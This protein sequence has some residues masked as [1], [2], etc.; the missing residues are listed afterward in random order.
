MNSG[1]NDTVQWLTDLDAHLARMSREHRMEVLMDS[2]AS[3][4][5]VMGRA[6]VLAVRSL[7]MRSFGPNGPLIELV[8]GHLAL[9]DIG[10][11]PDVG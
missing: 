5:A 9:R 4:V 1:P 11:L 2:L 6:E 8:D 7:L 10:E 3:I